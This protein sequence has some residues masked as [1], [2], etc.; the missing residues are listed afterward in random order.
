MLWTCLAALV[1]VSVALL[2]AAAEDKGLLLA[3]CSPLSAPDAVSLLPMWMA[4]TLVMMLPAGAPMLSTY[5]DIAESARGKSMEIVPPLI[6]AAGYTVVWL[7]AA[8]AGAFLQMLLG[9][10][11]TEAAGP[12]LIGAG[13]YQFAPLKHAC[14]TKC[15][16]PMPFFLSRWT[17]RRFGVFRMGAEQGLLC[18]GCCWALMAL[19]L[20]AGAMNPVWMAGIGALA[21]LEKTLPEPK[22][23]IY[24]AGMGLIGAG[25][26]MIALV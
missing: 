6:L 7:V 10:L 1:A 11:P 8:A 4:M 23:L 21:V 2:A 25:S 14:L 18:L 3:L 20:V 9:P 12:V 22:P 13:L 26:I 5:L 16:Q 15:R 19:S 24:G 17:L